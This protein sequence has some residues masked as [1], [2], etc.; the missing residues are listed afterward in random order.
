MLVTTAPRT[1]FADDDGPSTILFPS[2]YRGPAAPTRKRSC[3]PD[4][5]LRDVWDRVLKPW[6]IEE[7]REPETI[8]GYAMDL[9][10]WERETSSLDFG[11]GCFG[12]CGPP[13][14]QITRELLKEFRER[15][16]A[17]SVS[18]GTANRIFRSI[19]VILHRA[20]PAGRGNAEGEGLSDE[21]LNLKLL[22]AARP[23]KRTASLQQIGDWYAR[24]EG[25]TWP[26]DLH[27]A[28]PLWW[29][30]LLVLLCHYGFRTGDFLKLDW[31]H[32]FWSSDCP[33]S[34]SSVRN[35][36]G[37]IMFTPSKTAKKKPTPLVLPMTRVVRAHLQACWELCGSPRTGR[38][39]RCPVLRRTKKTAKG[40]DACQR[41]AE[42][43]LHEE[44]ALQQRRAGIVEPFTF[45]DLRK[46]CAT[47]LG[48]VDRELRRL[49]L[50]H[51]SRDVSDTYY[52]DGIATIRDKLPQVPM[53]EAFNRIFLSPDAPQQREL[54]D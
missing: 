8:D 14:S 30:T 27:V 3:S 7:G 32:V 6:L 39:F 5:T 16:K 36:H 2:V 4:S 52:F 53:P 18:A 25:A 13:V 42:E 15:V 44:R 19:N 24:T 29:K 40:G 51:A 26:V 48:R 11:G 12:A 45:Q 28:S 22:P 38:I 37:W 47:W 1:L 46:T 54:F 43:H 34:D 9:R 20:S 31:S 33:Q 21:W 50:G 17:I 35:N 23:T 10:R 49:V 41:T